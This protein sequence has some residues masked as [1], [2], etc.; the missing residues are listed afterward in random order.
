MYE[1][2]KNK[3]PARNVTVPTS[4]TWMEVSLAGPIKLEHSRI[5]T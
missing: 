1:I 5:Q 4:G 3:T 2:G